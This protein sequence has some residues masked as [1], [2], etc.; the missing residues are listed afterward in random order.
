MAY[1]NRPK[2][3]FGGAALLSL[4]LV[5]GCGNMKSAS[6]VPDQPPADAVADAGLGAGDGLGVQVFAVPAEGGT[7]FAVLHDIDRAIQVAEAKLE[8]GAYDQWFASFDRVDAD[9]AVA[10]VEPSEDDQ[11][12]QGEGFDAMAGVEVDTD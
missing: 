8:Q 5:G 1:V 2:L 3:V 6:L 12:A 10:N 11:D 7:G 4:A 9:T